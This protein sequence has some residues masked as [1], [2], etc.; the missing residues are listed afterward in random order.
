[1]TDGQREA[2][3][4]LSPRYCLDHLPGVINF[5]EAFG[6]AAPLSIEIG[7]GNGE[8][9]LTRC[10]ARPEMNHLGI[11]V[12][13]PG[14][15]RV[16]MNAQV[17]ALENMRVISHDAVDIIRHQIG[18]DSVDEFVIE[19]PDPWHK[20]RHHKR[21][22][23][24]AGFVQLLCLRLKRGGVLRLATD[25]ENYAEQMLQVLSAEDQLSNLAQAGG[26]VPRPESRPVTRFEARGTRLGHRVFD[27][28]FRRN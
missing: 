12:H 16:M 17:R 7:F 28:A 26:F 8:A 1:M 10:A 2:L 6:R 20:K 22:L 21:R 19:F 18:P 4:D 15:G 27:L 25:W 23:I 11:E 9:L 13:R 14:V 5:T 3:E 24:Q